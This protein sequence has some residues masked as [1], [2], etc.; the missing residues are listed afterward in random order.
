MTAPSW[1]PLILIERV[2]PIRFF[3]VARTSVSPN[4]PFPL[5]NHGRCVH[6]MCLHK[7]TQGNAGQCHDLSLSVSTTVWLIRP[8]PHSDD[9]NSTWVLVERTRQSPAS[10]NPFNSSL[11]QLVDARC[12]SMLSCRV[13]SCSLRANAAVPRP[14]TATATRAKPTGEGLGVLACLDGS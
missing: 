5:S 11:T 4:T 6:S 7:S 2:E 1:L 12:V 9:Y 10:H 3:L 14:L 8:W 13:L